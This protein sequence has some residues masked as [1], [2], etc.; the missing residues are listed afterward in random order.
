MN[1]SD[2]V[3]YPSCVDHMT[4]SSRQWSP[5]LSRSYSSSERSWHDR[6]GEKDTDNEG[7]TS[8]THDIPMTVGIRSKAMVTHQYNISTST[9]S[10]GLSMAETLA[11]GPHHSYS[12]SQ[13]CLMLNSF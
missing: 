8:A 5:S 1:S 4:Y 7:L 9:S 3:K 13:V 6:D 11:Q 2:S 10:M 12:P